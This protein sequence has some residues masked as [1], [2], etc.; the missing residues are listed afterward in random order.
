MKHVLRLLEYGCWDFFIVRV[1]EID[2]NGPCAL[3]VAFNAGR[4]IATGF[5]SA[6]CQLDVGA[7][8][9]IVRT[10]M[11]CCS[12]TIL[13]LR[14]TLFYTSGQLWALFDQLREDVSLTSGISGNNRQTSARTVWNKQAGRS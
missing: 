6:Q 14:V 9:D 2:L 1:K 7:T 12:V 8:E 4:L 10:D 13:T 5:V 11:I 3:R